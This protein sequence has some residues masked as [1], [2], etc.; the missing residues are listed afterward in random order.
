[1]RGENNALIKT[2]FALRWSGLPKRAVLYAVALH[3]LE[4]LGFSAPYSGIPVERVE[5]ASKLN[6]NIMHT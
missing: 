5:Y 1:M 6:G 2:E 3:D 4:R